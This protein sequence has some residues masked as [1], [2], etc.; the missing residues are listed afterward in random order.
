MIKNQ[1][2][3][4]LVLPVLLL[5]TQ[6]LSSNAVCIYPRSA[7]ACFGLP[8]LA[9]NLSYIAYIDALRAFAFGDAQVLQGVL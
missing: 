1:Y 8:E 2:H 6:D 7:R 4:D 9:A 5:P 3:L